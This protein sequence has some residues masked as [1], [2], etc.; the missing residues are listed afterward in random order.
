LLGRLTR[1]RRSSADHD[2]YTACC[3]AHADRTPSLAIKL[4]P[5]ERILLHCFAGCDT[6]AILDA[7]GLTFRDVCPQAL[8]AQGALP[9]VRQ[10]FSPALALQCLADESAL[11]AIAAADIAEAH[12]LSAATLARVGVAAGRIASALEVTHARR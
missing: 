10:P 4:L 5:D 1:V 3:P 6:E 12:A 11:L 8:R 7:L 9:P 2:A